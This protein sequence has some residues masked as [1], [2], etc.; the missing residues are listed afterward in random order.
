MKRKM[1]WL[2]PMVFVIS[3]MMAFSA[4]AAPKLSK[5]TAVL[6][7]N[8]S[9][10]WNADTRTYD[11]TTQYYSDS[12]IY[13]KGASRKAK[14][15][16][17]ES[18][19]FEVKGTYI[20]AGVNRNKFVIDLFTRMDDKGNDLLQPGTY[21]VKFKVRDKKKVYSYNLTVKVLNYMPR[22]ITYLKVGKQT[23]RSVF[24]Q[25]NA[26][27]ITIALPTGR[28]TIKFATPKGYRKASYF[29]IMRGSKFYSYRNGKK[30][31]LKKGDIL[32]LNYSLK[33]W[34]KDSSIYIRV[35]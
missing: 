10:S 13:L 28:Q 22:R 20:T 32:L 34:A 17:Y 21:T 29:A 15:I 6:Y 35:E 4:M 33:S 31:T 1:K 2:L 18:A 7:Q 16:S 11:T 14:V 9:L 27:C 8:D 23:F 19:Q 3:M 26:G 25:K 30:M 5:K 24:K 12:S